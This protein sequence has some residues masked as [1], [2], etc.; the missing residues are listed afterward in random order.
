MIWT[1]DVALLLFLVVLAIGVVISKNLLAAAIIFSAY[2]LL[3]SI[4]WTQM[5]APDV[6]LT[7]A[8][9]GAGVMT[10]LFVAAATKTKMREEE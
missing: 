9:V 8:A 1:L 7:E 3:M 5:N 2:S 10:L 4:V 6:A